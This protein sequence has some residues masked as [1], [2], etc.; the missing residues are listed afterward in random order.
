MS[1]A[2]E[3][4]QA[5]EACETLEAKE[6]KSPRPPIL[7]PGDITCVVFPTKYQKEQRTKTVPLWSM[8]TD[9]ARKSSEIIKPPSPYP[10]NRRKPGVTLPIAGRL[11]YKI[12][13]N[14][15]LPDIEKEPVQSLNQ[16]R[17]L[18]TAKKAKGK[19]SKRRR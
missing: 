3:M 7:K 12:I 11:P 16:V 9:L 2:K 5:S 19:R 18:V 14:E 8:P 4:K 10:P 17:P 1:A 6:L 15:S 13:L